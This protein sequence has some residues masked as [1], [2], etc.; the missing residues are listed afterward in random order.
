ME[1]VN[2]FIYP[3]KKKVM[4]SSL[5]FG[6]S[7]AVLFT[8]LKKTD[9]VFTRVRH[10]KGPRG[11]SASCTSGAPSGPRLLEGHARV[12]QAVHWG[13]HRAVGAGRGVVGGH[14]VSQ[15]RVF[16]GWGAMAPTCFHVAPP[17][18]YLLLL[19]LLAHPPFFILLLLLLFL[20]LFPFFLLPILLFFLLFLVPLFLLSFPLLLI[21]FFFLPSSSSYPP[22]PSFFFYPPLSSSSLYHKF[23]I[24]CYNIVKTT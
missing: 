24:G 18:L 4:T 6:A 7:G 21:I 15:V 22:P 20:L 14:R 5:E 2:C 3:I 8:L 12:A 13:G 16:L 1:A 10:I 11:W 19:L 17:L 23:D 9:D